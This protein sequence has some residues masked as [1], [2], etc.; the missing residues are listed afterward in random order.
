D[1][2]ENGDDQPLDRT[3]VMVRI[4]S[5][6]RFDPVTPEQRDE[7]EDTAERRD[8]A[9][10]PEPSP[11]VRPHRNTSFGRCG[12]VPSRA[13]VSSRACTMSSR[14]QPIDLSCAT[15]ENRRRRGR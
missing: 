13:R 8:G 6:D 4:E 7:T 10:E 15:V 9:L 12:D 5:G 14:V 1:R 3:V 2:K 11:N